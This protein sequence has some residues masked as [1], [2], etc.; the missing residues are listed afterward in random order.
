MLTR[1]LNVF[2]RGEY[3]KQVTGHLSIYN[4]RVYLNG[5]SVDSIVKSWEMIPVSIIF[6]VSPR[7][8][9][10]KPKTVNFFALISAPPNESDKERLK[11]LVRRGTVSAAILEKIDNTEDALYLYL[12][13]YSKHIFSNP[14]S[15][16][17]DRKLG[18]SPTLR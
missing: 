15:F 14:A 6:D 10:K 12:S 3:K 11:N 17:E 16:V 13:G 5:I 7:P 2:T 4:N 18:F 1:L 9:K 8:Y